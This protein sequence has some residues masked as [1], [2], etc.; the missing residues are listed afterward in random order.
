MPIGRKEDETAKCQKE[1]TCASLRLAW[2]HDHWVPLCAHSIFQTNRTGLFQRHA[3]CE[4][5]DIH[6]TGRRGKGLADRFRR[7]KFLATAA[8]PNQHD[9]VRIVSMRC[10][11]GKAAPG[12]SSRAVGGHWRA[13]TAFRARLP[14]TMAGATFK[15]HR[16]RVRKITKT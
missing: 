3:R 8:R 14:A 10:T 15:M 4:R 2:P 5:G 11:G 6:Q 1:I 7:R 13:L 12:P 9:S 16:V